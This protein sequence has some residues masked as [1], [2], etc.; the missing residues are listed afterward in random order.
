V[1]KF[2]FFFLIFILVNNLIAQKLHIKNYTTDDGLPISQVWCSLQDSKGYIWFGTS[3][4][5]A[6]YN[7]VEFVTYTVADGLI[8]NTVRSLFED[9]GILW[10]ATNNGISKFD[11]NSFKNYTA[12]EGLGK[13]IVR[14]ITKF[15]DY[16]WFGTKEGLSRFDPEYSGEADQR[17]ITYTTE[18]GLPSNSIFPLLSDGQYLWLGT[19]GGGL[20]RFDGK[21][22]INYGEKDG[23][24]CKFIGALAKNESV[25]WIGTVNEGLWKF[26]NGKFTKISGTADNTFYCAAKGKDLWFGTLGDG[27]WRL[28]NNG[29][30]NYT[31]DNGLTNNRIYSILVDKENSVWFTT[32]NGVSKLVSDKFVSYLENKIILSVCMFKDAMWFGSMEGLFKLEN[33]KLTSY[34]TKDGLISNRVWSLAPFRGKLWIGTEKGLNSFDGKKFKKYTVKEGLASN[35]VYDILPA[36]ETL[37][38]ATSG[39]AIKFDGK[40]FTDYTTSEGLVH[41]YVLSLCQD[42]DK[43]WFAT[44]GGASCFDGNKFINFTTDDGLSSNSVRKIFKDSRDFLWFGTALGINKFD[45]EYSR[46]AGKKFTA[47]TTKDGLSNN[48]VSS[49]VE[50][51]GNLWLGTDKGLNI[52]NGEKVIRIYYRKNG[53]IGDESFNHNS[54]YLDKNQNIWFGSTR[55][56]TKYISKNDVPN[57][58]PPA[59]YI[60]KFFVNDSLIKQKKNLKF[61]Y[62]RNN[63][64]FSYIGLSFKDEDDVRYQFKLDGY[65]KDW[66]E[67][68]EKREIRYTNLNNGDY[69]F[70]VLARNGDGYWSGTPAELSFVILPPFWETWWFIGLSAIGFSA[71]IFAGY[72]YRIS[73]IK[74]E[75]ERLQRIVNERTTELRGKNSDLS[76][77]LANIK[78][79]KGLLPICAS[80]KKIRDDKGYWNQIEVYIMQHSEADF[81]HGL[82]PECV[83]K[84]YPGIKLDK[85]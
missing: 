85:K 54:L 20:S 5:L 37:W 7:G 22:F 41:N 24:L 82:C 60:E 71:L 23:F 42:G 34:T 65:D 78:R 39:G 29:F 61:E 63:V 2:S 14:S 79:L 49:I 47:F 73:H 57:R 53:L 26:E 13:G 64:S 62:K 1:R 84:L 18:G 74:R 10:I 19:L 30:K 25:L 4:G 38:L 48:Y 43:I 28:G 58:V 32:D 66:S 45:P 31:I 6:R 35:I 75:K 27:V 68:T 70:R 21:N 50:S 9:K 59:V 76:E 15:K 67:I 44:E 69:T 11:G 3:S 17:F 81:S 40:K 33:H 51:S 83:K 56:V 8:N 46:Q 12:K 55:G 77:A 52:F 16:L 80:C 36:G 72:R